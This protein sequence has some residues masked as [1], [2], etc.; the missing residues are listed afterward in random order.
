MIEAG[1][2]TAT[3]VGLFVVIA[4]VVAGT[5]IL[6]IGVQVPWV[7]RRSNVTA[8]FDD[9]SGLREGALVQVAGVTVGSVSR[10][11]LAHD[12]GAVVRMRLD[13]SALRDLRAD[14]SADLRTIGL[15]GDRV[16]ALSPGRAPLPLGPGQVLPGRREVEPGDVMG[17]A[18][19]A[20]TR[21]EQL[22]AD[23][24]RT[25]LRFDQSG[26]VEDLAAAAAAFRGVAERA[27]RGPGLLHD[28][29]YDRAL[30]ADVRAATREL[31]RAGQAADGAI[32]KLDRASADAA[33]VAA[34]IRSGQGTVGGLVY[35]PAIYENLRTIVGNVSRS[36]ILRALV[37][38]SLHNREEPPKPPR[39]APAQRRPR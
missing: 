20:A 23:L 34:H 29:A 13:R 2:R 16:V 25:V 4:G 8:R 28:V 30:A 32:A 10:I 37:R 19:E 38:L 3:V 6:F 1:R 39:P 33:A 15:L 26:A 35:D 9:V 22:L 27:Q 21:L 17:R 31:R 36:K 12:G 24:D 11:D 18:A 7:S 14:A 5:I